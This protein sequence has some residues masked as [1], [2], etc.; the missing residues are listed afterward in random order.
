MEEKGGEVVLPQKTS[1]HNAK[2]M[3]R[4]T[5][6]CTDQLCSKALPFSRW[7]LVFN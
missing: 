2:R 1:N 6:L 4:R 3:N 5:S 7:L